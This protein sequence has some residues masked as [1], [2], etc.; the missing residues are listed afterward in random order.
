MVRSAPLIAG[1]FAAFV[2]LF[3]SYLGAYYAMLSGQIYE[4]WENFS[5]GNP[6]DPKYRIHNEFVITALLP[7][8]QVDYYV[9]FDYWNPQL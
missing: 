3:A 8:H 6:P 9:R 1:I 5:L 2:L 7:A 4:D